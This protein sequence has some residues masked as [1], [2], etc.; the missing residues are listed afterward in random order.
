MKQKIILLMVLIAGLAACSKDE[1][2]YDYSKYAVDSEIIVQYGEF[3]GDW[4]LNQQKIETDTLT[5]M[6]D[7]F[8]VK[9]PS[10]PLIKYVVNELPQ[11]GAMLNGKESYDYK[12]DA[13]NMPNVEVETTYGS[14]I[15]PYEHQGYSSNNAYFNVDGLKSTVTQ[16]YC[17]IANGMVN[18]VTGGYSFFLSVCT[19]QPMVAVFN[20]DTNLWTL[21][22]TLT[23]IKYSISGTDGEKTIDLQLPAELLF[24]ATKKLGNTETD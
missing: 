18:D 8:F 22:I 19:D 21:K 3:E 12:S 15:W 16:T 13:S 4:I 24:V 23:K 14:H 2:S 5:V 10:V 17:T 11:S 9:A 7:H 1:E 6:N 20:R